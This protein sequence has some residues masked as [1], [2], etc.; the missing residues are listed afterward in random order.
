[1]TEQC[2][3]NLANTVLRIDI[4]RRGGHTHMYTPRWVGATVGGWVQ[5]TPAW[6]LSG[7]P[8]LEPTLCPFPYFMCFKFFSWAIQKPLDTGIR[9]GTS[10][11]GC[12]LGWF[13]CCLFSKTCNNKKDILIASSDTPPHWKEPAEVVQA[14]KFRWLKW[15]YLSIQT[16]TSFSY[17]KALHLN[18][19]H[20]AFLLFS[21]Y[22]D[23]F[24]H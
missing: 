16:S 10:Q 7:W 18:A 5:W 14:S 9:L 1:M 6:G 4:D 13:V 24:F 23:I 21:G 2:V 22:G 20:R 15:S 19:H 3:T 12:S 11:H 17:N 8:G